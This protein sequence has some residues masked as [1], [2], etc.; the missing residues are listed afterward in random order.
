LKV[1]HSG[2]SIDMMLWQIRIH[3]D[4]LRESEKDVRTVV[5]YKSKFSKEIDPQLRSRLDQGP[6]ICGDQ[7]SAADVSLRAVSFGLD[8]MDYA[9]V[10]RSIF[11]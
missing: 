6:F 2:A 8:Y 11:I 4:I 5:R 9:R 7:F 1:L 3:E 10:N